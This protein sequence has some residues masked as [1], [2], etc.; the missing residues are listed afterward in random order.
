MADQYAPFDPNGGTAPMAPPPGAPVQRQATP[1]FS[2]AIL[3]A[4]KAIA[5]AL[6]PKSITQR[7]QVVDQAVNRDSGALGDQF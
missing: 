7:G 5:Q 4:V 3:D 6:A 2:G 1:G